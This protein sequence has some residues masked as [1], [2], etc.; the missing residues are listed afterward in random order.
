M[1]DREEICSGICQVLSSLPPTARDKPYHA[2]CLPTIECIKSMAK[3]ADDQCANGQHENNLSPI[4]KR[5]GD[6]IK[7][8][9]TLVKAFAGVEHPSTPNQIAAN[10]NTA[11]APKVSVLL[12]REIWPCLTQVAGK[13]ASFKV[14]DSP[15]SVI[16]LV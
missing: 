11:P 8:L 6:E 12:M 16:H 9:A 3:M 13:F 7:V 4:L 10:P 1:D 14:S 15:P 2:F 5:M